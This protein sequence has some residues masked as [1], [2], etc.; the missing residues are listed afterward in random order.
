M[1]NLSPELLIQIV[2]VPQGQEYESV[3]R[4]LNR[5]K[6][7]IPVVSPIPAGMEAIR[8]HFQSCHPQQQLGLKNPSLSQPLEGRIGVLV[9]GLCGSLTSEFAVGDAVLYDSC[10]NAS[11]VKQGTE[12]FCDRELTDVLAQQLGLK[13]VQ[14][15]TS[16]RVICKA[17]EKRSLAAQFP[18]QVVDMEGFAIL[19]QLNSPDIAVAMLRVVSDDCRADLPDLSGSFSPEG[20]LLPLPLAL[21]MLRQPLAAIQLIQGSLKGLQVLEELATQLFG[22]GVK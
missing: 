14:A 9:M 8:C 1:F 19:E 16:D 5:T 11:A 6:L 3:C 18:A 17:A 2:Y 10:I 4:G 20:A 13:R 21:A 7:L 15:V 22:P 12:Q